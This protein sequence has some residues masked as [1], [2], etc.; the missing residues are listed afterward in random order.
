MRVQQAIIV[1]VHLN[2]AI[3]QILPLFGL[4]DILHILLSALHNQFL[5]PE[6]GLLGF[7]VVLCLGHLGER[8]SLSAH[9]VGIG[10]Y[11]N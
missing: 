7:E 6:T 10:K 3:D 2:G 4:N 1:S 9:Q 8:V 11:Y 5:A